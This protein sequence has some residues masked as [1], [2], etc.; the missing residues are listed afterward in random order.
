MGSGVWAAGTV[1]RFKRTNFGKE[2]RSGTKGTDGLHG[3]VCDIW[4]EAIVIHTDMYGPR[5]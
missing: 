2:K 3:E 4:Y 5:E 1:R